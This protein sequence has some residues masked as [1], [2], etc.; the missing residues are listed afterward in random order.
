MYSRNNKNGRQPAGIVPP[1]YHGTAVTREPYIAQNKS[2]NREIPQASPKV[3][4]PEPA[5]STPEEAYARRPLEVR[6]KPQSSFGRGWRSPLGT[7]TAGVTDT[8]F[9]GAAESSGNSADNDLIPG[10]QPGCAAPLPVFSGIG[11]EEILLSAVLLLLLT[12]GGENREAL[13]LVALL[14]I[15]GL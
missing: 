2:Q 8:T 4:I 1:G 3:S 5:V 15:A 12:G 11:S 10:D 14:F 13:L 7:D 6:I 9:N